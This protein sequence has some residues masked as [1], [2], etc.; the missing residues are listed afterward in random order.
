MPI[1]CFLL[2]A[3][4]TTSVPSIRATP[5]PRIRWAIVLAP[6]AAPPRLARGHRGTRVTLQRLAADAL[7]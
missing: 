1:L 3:A 7:P 6:G 2:V 5:L 4:I